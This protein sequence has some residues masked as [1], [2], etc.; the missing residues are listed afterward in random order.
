MVV[1][2]ASLLVEEGELP[3]LPGRVVCA[4]PLVLGLQSAVTVSTPGSTARKAL[5]MEAGRTKKHWFMEMAKMG[6]REMC[7]CPILPPAP[8]VDVHTI[9]TSASISAPFQ[10]GAAC[11]V[12][13]YTEAPLAP[14]TNSL[15]GSAAAS[16]PHNQPLHLPT[17][18]HTALYSVV[19][20]RGCSFRVL[21]DWFTL[22]TRRKFFSL[23]L[24]LSDYL[25]YLPPGII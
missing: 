8:T 11:V 3:S 5:C 13:G 10:V 14:S 19:D 25:N 6:I 15:A 1:P 23:E 20:S 4:A 16:W 2:T 21:Q 18:S 22:D 24:K 17:C 7:S 9:V 12:F